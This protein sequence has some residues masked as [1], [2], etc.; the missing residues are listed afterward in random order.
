MQS[1]SDTAERVIEIASSI[2]VDG[3]ASESGGE[4][5]EAEETAAGQG[6]LVADAFFAP[7]SPITVAVVL[8]QAGEEDKKGAIAE[9]RRIATEVGIPEAGLHLGGRPV[10]G[11]ALNDSVKRAA[12]NRD[13]PII[14]LP[15]R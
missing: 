6:R 11:R 10:A 2:S 12:W 13:F 14:N 7:G 9:L 5:S 15:G 4:A 3:G 1:R 8:S